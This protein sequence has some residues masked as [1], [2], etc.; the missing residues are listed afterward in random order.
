MYA[1]LL[2][3]LPSFS[4]G[5]EPPLTVAA[6]AERCRPYLGEAAC[7]ALE[8]PA[9]AASTAGE[10]GDVARLWLDGERQLRNA[11]ARRRAATWQLPSDTDQHEHAAFRVDIEAGVA[12]AFEAPDPLQRER[13]LDDLRWRLLDDLAGVVPWGYAALFAYAQRLRL[14][15]A[16]SRRLPDAGSR[17]L[18]SV[19]NGLEAH[20]A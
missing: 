19:L 14:A 5:D 1:F 13:A 2:S 7:A 9:P 10:V 18:H 11:V 4:L 20:H 6:L 17:H 3:S 12:H 8:H 15:A 16:W